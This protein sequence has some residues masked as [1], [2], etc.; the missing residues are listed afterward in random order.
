MLRRDLP[1]LL[2]V[3]SLMAGAFLFMKLAV[4]AL[5]AA[6]LADVRVLAA[7]AVLAGW[8]AVRGRRLA[9]RRG[10]GPYLLLG[11]LNAALPFT[12]TAWGELQ[13]P[14]SL[15]AVLMATIPLFAALLSAAYGHERLTPVRWAGVALGLAGVA[16]LTGWHPMGLDARALVSI[17]AVLGS[18]LAYAFGSVYAK[19][20]FADVDRTSMT[21]GNFAA[22]GVLLLPLALTHPP[23]ALPG[24]D[25]VLAMA[26][27]VVLSTALSFRLYFRLIELRGPTVA[28]S[29]GYL[30]PVFGTMWGVLFLGEPLGLG[31]VIGSLI[32]L[33]AVSLVTATPHGRARPLA[34]RWLRLRHRTVGGA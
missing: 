5:G 12:L 2:L 8:S 29:I 17:L 26:G 14:A 24:S 19:R 21:V 16:V 25:V 23:S 7:A 6:V 9:F 27:L 22:A 20:A 13:L 31:S 11:A 33:L 34:A 18:A 10:L 28:T 15:A 30:I 3:A 1:Q 4:P 32:V